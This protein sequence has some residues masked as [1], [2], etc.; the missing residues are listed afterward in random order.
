MSS[1]ALR[2]FVALALPDSVRDELVRWRATAMG[3]VGGL[4]AVQRSDLH[5]TLCF[6]GSRPATDVAAVLEVCGEACA[7]MPAA[8][9]TLGAALWLPRR[10]PRVLSVA[11]RDEGGR[12]GAV[13]A[14]LSRGLAGA[15]LFAPEARPFV[16]HVT[17]ARVRGGAHVRPGM[18]P[19]PAPGAFA[20]TTVTLYVSHLGPGGARY[21]PLG[22]I[23]LAGGPS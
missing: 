18:L 10:A 2:L 13:Q 22:G 20:G 9:L 17:V 5:V 1:E 23:G 4:R 3:A 19:E 6:L 8:A 12:L 16:P 7:G 14:A 11:L 15:G 21:E